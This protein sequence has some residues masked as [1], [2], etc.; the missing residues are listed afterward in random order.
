[1]QDN[2][3]MAQQ[4]EEDEIELA[5]A[6]PS[7]ALASFAILCT[8]GLYE[9]WRHAAKITVTNRKVVITRGVIRRRRRT[10]P[11]SSIQDVNRTAIPGFGKILITTA[12]GRDSVVASKWLSGRDA[13]V[14][15]RAVVSTIARR[16]QVHSGL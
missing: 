14:I 13:R 7:V 6:H 1:M 8:S 16:D 10:L 4:P 11:I 5:S 12:G 2:P 9:I 3:R 15:E